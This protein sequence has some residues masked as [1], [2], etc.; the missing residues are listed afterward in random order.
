MAG[1]MT[2]VFVLRWAGA[3]AGV[4]ASMLYVYSPYVGLTA[5]HVL[6]DLPGVIGLSL[7]PALLWCVH[8]LMSSNRMFDFMLAALSSCALLLVDPK[9]ASVGT[10]LA[11]MLVGYHVSTTRNIG[12]GVWTVFACLVGFLLA[13]FYWMPALLEQNA[14]R[15]QPAPF[16]PLPLALDLAEL[17]S[18]LR[19]ID[20]NELVTTPQLTLG[21]G[22]IMFALLGGVGVVIGHRNRGLHAMYLFSGVVIIVI[23]VVVLPGEVWLLGPATLCF[24]IGASAAMKESDR[25]PTRF[26]R[27]VLPAMLVVM[28]FVSMPVW[29]PPRWPSA[30][31]GVDA[32]EQVFYE[33]QDSNRCTAARRKC[34]RDL[35]RSDYPNRGLIAG[36]QRGEV[37]RIPQDEMTSEAQASLLLSE[38]HRDRY[39]VNVVDEV[40]FD[41]MRADFPVGRRFWLADT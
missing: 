22:I 13:S 1:A 38:S 35:I 41:L 36:Y 17:T 6:G 32:S 3:R 40:T 5:P 26:D 14:V 16:E 30:F 33:Q 37:M 11:L 31:G 24:A 2:Y 7:L 10:I 29:L 8:R 20:L 18:M 39:Q 28:L 34:N 23:G 15:W 19:R 9:T 27:L 4:L 12:Q 21:W 25:F